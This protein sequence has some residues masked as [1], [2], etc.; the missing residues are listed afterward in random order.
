MKLRNFL[1]A[2]LLMTLTTISWA[3]SYPEGTLSIHNSSAKKI[4]AQVSSFG[5]FNLASNESREVSYST[6]SSVCASTPTQC[7]TQFF[8]DDAP[9]GTAVINVTTGKLI[10]MKLHALKVKIVKGAEEVIR[11]VVIK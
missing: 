11:T 10:S 4:T 3:A 8:I 7:R 1:F 9:V 2:F 6:L 5:K